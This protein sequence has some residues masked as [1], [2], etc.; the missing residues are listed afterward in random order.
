VIAAEPFR[1][2]AAKLRLG[3]RSER[4]SVTGLDEN[5]VMN[6]VLDIDLEAVSLPKTGLVLST[7]MAELLGARRGDRVTVEALEG[8]RPVVEVPVTA[9]IEEYIAAPAYMHRL[10]LNRLMGEGRLVSGAYIQVDA[11][12]AKDLYRQ[13][14]DTPAVAGVTLQTAALSTFRKTMA[15]TL[16]IMMSFYVLFGGLIAVGVVYNSA[17]VSLS[18]RGRELASLRVLGFTRG[19]VSYILL[20]EL[21]IL[22]LAALPFGCFIGFGLAHV[23]VTNL[24]TELFRLPLVIE[25]ATYALAITTVLVASVVSGLIVRRRIDSFDLIA[26]LKTRE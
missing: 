25:P 13:L 5:T 17:R 1:A 24:D 19:E 26:V 23:I 22:T 7:K 15:E 12:R 8:R 2:V 10:A 3:I 14:K 9:I 16:D 4:A 18:E 6:R 20:G 11:N 21:A